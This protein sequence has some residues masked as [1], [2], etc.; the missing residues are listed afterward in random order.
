M[1]KRK[2]LRLGMNQ[3]GCVK[4]LQNIPCKHH[5]WDGWER[6]SDLSDIYWAPS[7]SRLFFHFTQSSEQPYETDSTI[8]RWR[9][10]HWEKYRNL[11]KATA[12]RKW[13]RWGLGHIVPPGYSD[14]WNRALPLPHCLPKM[15]RE[16]APQ[17]GSRSWF[18]P[19][20]GTEHIQGSPNPSPP[21]LHLPIQLLLANGR[22]PTHHN[23]D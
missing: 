16:G 13:K 6:N 21:A 7:I 11:L 12:A 20:Q 4:R 1:K 5:K 8:P 3:C 10:W 2:I 17:P 19:S 22:S 14:P 18:I 23:N 9:T 15:G